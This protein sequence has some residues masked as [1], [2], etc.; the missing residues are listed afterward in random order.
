MKKERYLEIW[1][2][3]WEENLSESEVQNRYFDQIKMMVKKEDK[4]NYLSS[5]KVLEK[6]TKL[7]K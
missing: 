2:S 5:K 3:V 7:S 6:I 1:N 4:L